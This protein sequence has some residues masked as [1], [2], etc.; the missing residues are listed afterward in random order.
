MCSHDL[1]SATDKVSD[2][3]PYHIYELSERSPQQHFEGNTTI[4]AVITFRQS[5]TK[6]QTFTFI[7]NSSDKL[8]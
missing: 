3:H 6:Y 1:K 7:I 2:H 4:S 5:L 8:L